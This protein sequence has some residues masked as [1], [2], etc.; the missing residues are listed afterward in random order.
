MRVRTE[1]LRAANEELPGGLPRSA[2][3]ADAAHPARE[4]GLGR[5]ARGRGRPRAQQPHRLR[6]LQRRR[7]SRTSSSG[8]APCWRSTGPRRCP[9]AA[10]A[11]CRRAWERRKIDYALR[12]LDSMIQ[13]IREGAERSAEDRARPARVRAQPGRRLAAGRPARGDRVEPHPAQPPPQGPG[14]RRPQA[15]ATLPAVECIR[16]QIDQVFLNL[17]ANAAQAIAGPG[18]DHH[19]DAARGGTRWSRSPTPAPASPPTSSA[20]SSTRSSPPSRWARAPG[21]ALSISYEIVKK[22]GGEIRAESPAGGGAVF[23][24]APPHRPAAPA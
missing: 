4:D 2:G 17:L 18:R 1:Q 19:R 5:P 12:Y 13:G 8:C 14:H 11:A 15:S 3:H 9:E 24:R 23:T 7:R 21:S 20:G 10:R 22:H 16:S 6:L